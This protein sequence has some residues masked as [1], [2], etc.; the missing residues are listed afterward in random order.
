M[1][2]DSSLNMIVEK[3]K[4]FFLYICSI[5][6]NNSYDD[7]SKNIMSCNVLISLQL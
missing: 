4:N 5:L 3:V 2:I 7:S 1:N 6:Q